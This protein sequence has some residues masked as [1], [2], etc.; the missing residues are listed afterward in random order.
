[1]TVSASARTRRQ[2]TASE[3]TSADPAVIVSSDTHIGPRLVEDLRPYCP[4]RYLGAF[5]E[6][7]AR[8]AEQ[9]AENYRLIGRQAD[10]HQ[11]RPNLD[12]QDHYDPRARLADLDFDGVAAQVIFHGSQNEEPMPFG[13]ARAFSP[14]PADVELLGVGRQIYNRWIADFVTVEPERQVGLVYPSMWSVED[15]VDEIRWGREHGLR[16]VNLP[17]PRPSLTPYN[18]PLWAVCEELDMPLTTHAGG[19]DATTWRGPEARALL[20]L[21][22]GGPHSRRG[23]A[24]LI[25]GG[26]FERHPGLRLVLTEQPGD[27]WTYVLRELD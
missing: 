12:T 18:D 1:M 26:V 2:S 14:D 6:F 25:F 9:R 8:I 17:T 11:D 5:D 20:S 22:S 3:P 16:S 23:L 10:V 21:E 19:G 24:H 7:A 15:S 13:T 27:W 4:R